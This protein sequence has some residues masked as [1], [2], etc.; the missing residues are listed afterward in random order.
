MLSSGRH[1]VPGFPLV[2]EWEDPLP[3]ISGL[4]LFPAGKVPRLLFTACSTPFRHAQLPEGQRYLQEALQL[5][6]PAAVMSSTSP[7][8]NTAE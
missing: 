5:C 8:V 7:V 1:P 6:I 3:F 2:S 4:D